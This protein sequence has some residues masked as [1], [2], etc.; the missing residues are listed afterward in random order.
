M[1]HK[2]NTQRKIEPQWINHL[3]KES[4]NLKDSIRLAFSESFGAKEA[5]NPAVRIPG[6]GDS[7]EG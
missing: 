5:N 3:S 1:G 4:R 6:L 7:A 2:E